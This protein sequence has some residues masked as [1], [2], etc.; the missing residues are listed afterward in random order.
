MATGKE[1]ADG[2]SIC[3][4]ILDDLRSQIQ[5][6]VGFALS[7]KEIEA[8]ILELIDKG[9]VHFEPREEGT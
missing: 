2:W 8:V 6:K 9:F 3:Y 5:P 1:Y 4:S 7:M